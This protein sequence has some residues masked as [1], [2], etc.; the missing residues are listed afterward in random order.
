MLHLSAG[1]L[2]SAQCLAAMG[3]NWGL[4]IKHDEEDLGG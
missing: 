2:R 4:Y 1:T 3:Q